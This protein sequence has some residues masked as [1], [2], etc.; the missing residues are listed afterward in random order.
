MYSALGADAVGIN[1]SVGPDQLVAVVRNIKEAVS[2]PVIAYNVPGRTGVEIQ[3]ATMAKKFREYHSL[4]QYLCEHRKKYEGCNEIVFEGTHKPSGV[5]VIDTEQDCTVTAGEFYPYINDYLK[6]ARVIAE[7]FRLPL[8]IY[9]KKTNR[10]QIITKD[11]Y[12]KKPL[13]F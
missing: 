6:R 12:M 2:I 4:A 5:F 9:Q 3:P 10:V 13:Q 7:A 8:V 1:C 11:T